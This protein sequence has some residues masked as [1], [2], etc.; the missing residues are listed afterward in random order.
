MMTPFSKAGAVVV[1]AGI[2]LLVF[3]LLT[4]SSVRYDRGEPSSRPPDFSAWLGHLTP[5][6]VD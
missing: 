5:S 3:A 2:A 1:L 6:Q 4:D